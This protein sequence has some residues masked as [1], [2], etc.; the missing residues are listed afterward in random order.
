MIFVQDM[1]ARSVY[2]FLFPLLAMALCFY[3]LGAE[4]LDDIWPSV[5]V[6]IGF[7]GIQLVLIS[8]W[9]S[10]RKR[11]WTNITRDLLGWG[12]IL[13]LVSIA[14]GLSVFSFLVFFTAS[15]A[16]IALLWA[17]FRAVSKKSNRLVPL[18]GLQALLLALILSGDWWLFHTDLAGDEWLFKLIG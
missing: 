16:L 7:L 6:N 4:A 13:F 3:R 10:F 14:F 15:L 12:D 2:W 5:L 8:A 17:A 1:R 18:A 9:F 11:E